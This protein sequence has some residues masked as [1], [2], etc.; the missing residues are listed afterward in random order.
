MLCKRAKVGIV[1]TKRKRGSTTLGTLVPHT[2]RAYYMAL[3]WKLSN[4]P[5]PQLPSP[6]DYSWDTW[7]KWL[8]ETNLLSKCSSSGSAARAEKMQL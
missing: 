8:L 1:G 2:S 6:T 7:D 4:T 3:V 5:Y